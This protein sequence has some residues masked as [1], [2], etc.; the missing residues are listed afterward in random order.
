[1]I[2]IIDAVIKAGTKI[3]DK[4]WMD[5]S[6]KETLEFT[7][8]QFIEQMKFAVKQLDQ[9]G[10][11]AELE[12]IFRESQ[13][14]RDYQ[15]KMFGSA[16]ALKDFLVGRV[17]LLGRASIRWVIVGFAAW[18]TKRIVGIVLTDDVIKALIDNKLGIQGMWLVTILVVLIVA[19]PLA[20]VTGASVE[21]ILKS[22]GVI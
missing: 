6:E 15:I 4:F 12:L 1:M 13:A 11:L 8:A 19:I 21:K 20:Y 16:E 17:I 2:P 5:K 7:K 10:E 9:S 18:Q 22:R 14:Q 3:A